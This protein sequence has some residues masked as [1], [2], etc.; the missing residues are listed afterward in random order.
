MSATSRALTKPRFN[1]GQDDGPP[2]FLITI[3]T[4]GDNLWGRPK[5]VTT[6]NVGFLPRFQALCESWGFKPTYLVDYD[7]ARSAVFIEFGKEVLRRG[8]AEIGMHLHAWS[9]PPGYHLT[10]DDVVHHPYL[11][12]YPEPVIVDK[13]AF[14]TD[15]LGETFGVAI[16]SHRAGRWAFNRVYAEALLAEG[17]RVD[18]SVTPGLSWQAHRGHPRG[19]GGS[20]YRQFPSRAYFIDLDDISRPGQ[21]DLLEIPMT[22]MPCPFELV[23]RIRETSAE[24]SVLRRAIDRFFP[25]H[26]WFRP[27][28]DNLH[29]MLSV[30]SHVAKRS[31]DY[32]EFMLH[33]SELM[34]GGSPSFPDEA[35]SEKLY[36]NLNVLFDAAAGRFQGS[37]LSEYYEALSRE[38][39]R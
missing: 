38:D 3:D 37:T 20:D 24:R 12:E 15:L 14:M 5:K 34:P 25:P 2:R 36:Q 4:E 39:S 8:T 31:L 13:V 35:A 17:Y 33:S 22:I 19:S 1:G 26:T 29:R 7:A 23:N 11:I 9:T 32:V 21:S 18:C 16:R 27:K 6:E 28:T 30:L 10:Q